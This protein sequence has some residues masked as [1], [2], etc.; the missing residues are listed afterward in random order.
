[1]A[2][3][4]LTARRRPLCL[5]LPDVAD[6]ILYNGQVHTVG[7]GDAVTEAIAIGEGKVLATGSTDAIRRLSGRRTTAIDLRGRTVLPGINDS[8]LHLAYW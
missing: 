5:V 4:A 3:A 7:P 6:V 1:M 2:A 8:H